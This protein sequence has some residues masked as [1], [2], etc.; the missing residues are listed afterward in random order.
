MCEHPPVPESPDGCTNT[1]ERG[2]TPEEGVGDAAVRGCDVRGVRCH[3]RA[4]DVHGPGGV[5]FY[6][7]QRVRPIV[8][9]ALVH[10]CDQ[11]CT[12]RQR[13]TSALIRYRSPTTAFAAATTTTTGNT[14]ILHSKVIS[15]MKHSELCWGRQHWFRRCGRCN[16]NFWGLECASTTA[17]CMTESAFFPLRSTTASI[18]ASSVAGSYVCNQCRCKCGHGCNALAQNMLDL[19]PYFAVA[20]CGWY[21]KVKLKA[22]DLPRGCLVQRFSLLDQMCRNGVG[23]G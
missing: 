11:R 6:H 22:W 23:G 16:S 3:G 17:I 12:A 10:Q 14:R 1:S 4:E 20:D 18:T 19:Q 7:R 2:T 15:Q 9:G 21:V 8:S 5:P 13:S